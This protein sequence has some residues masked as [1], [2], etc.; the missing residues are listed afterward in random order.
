M[1]SYMVCAADSIKDLESTVNM[2]LNLGYKVVGSLVVDR[3]NWTNEDGIVIEV[4]TFWQP[5]AIV[6]HNAQ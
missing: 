6:M 5:I 4:V 3:H 1:K 2:K